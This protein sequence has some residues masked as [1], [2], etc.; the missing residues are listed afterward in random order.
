MQTRLSD[1]RKL[2]QLRD[3]QVLAESGPSGELSQARLRLLKLMFVPLE[4]ALEI[5][6]VMNR[7]P[8]LDDALEAQGTVVAAF[9]DEYDMSAQQAVDTRPDLT[10]E[11][12][13]LMYRVEELQATR[14]ALVVHMTRLLRH[15]GPAVRDELLAWVETPEPPAEEELALP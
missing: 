10:L 3:S 4:M 12:S 13:R 11:A 6:D 2:R 9:E 14:A 7:F 1:L 5:H 15:F 8:T